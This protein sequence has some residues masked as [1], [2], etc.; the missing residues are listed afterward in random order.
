MKTSDFVSR[1]GAIE[2]IGS[3]AFLGDAFD[4]PVG[5][6]LGPLTANGATFIGK[7]AERQDADMGKFAQERDSIV[8]QLKSQKAQQRAQLFQDSVVAGLV[9]EGKIKKHTDVINRLIARYRG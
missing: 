9:R 6:V 7:L 1:A 5:T 3:A 4:K 8:T 2:G